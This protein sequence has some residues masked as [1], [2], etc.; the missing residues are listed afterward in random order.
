MLST[1]GTYDLGDGRRGAVSAQGGQEDRGVI[2]K[3]WTIISFFVTSV[4]NIVTP[5]FLKTF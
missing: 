1:Y 5:D 3:T 2:Q 4:F